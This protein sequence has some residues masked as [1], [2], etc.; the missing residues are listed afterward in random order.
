[1]ATTLTRAASD[2][3]GG[4]QQAGRETTRSAIRGVAGEVMSAV[5]NAALRAVVDI[6]V[7]QV[8]RL[9]GRLD[10][11]AERGGTGVREALTGRP[12][13]ARSDRKPAHEAATAVRARMGATFGL[14]VAGAVK[15]LQ[16]LQRLA[17]RLLEALRRVVRRP[18]R[19][20]PEPEA[21]AHDEGPAREPT[22]EG[23]PA[24]RRETRRERRG[25]RTAPPPT[26]DRAGTRRR[27]T[28]NAPTN[29]SP[30]GVVR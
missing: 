19:A 9:A 14:V 16:F 4:V 6:G 7:S 8:D 15:L 12:S 23:E 13:P 2:T 1:M 30:G 25:R 24:E 28:R 18:R 22:G 5:G 29:G 11:V 3:T 10:A 17:L 26:R 21:G 27:R 20:L